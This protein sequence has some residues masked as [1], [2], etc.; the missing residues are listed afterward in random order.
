MKSFHHFLLPLVLGLAPLAA[1]IPTRAPSA[2]VSIPGRGTKGPTPE[3]VAKLK[4]GPALPYKVDASWPQMPD[5]YNFNESSGI[6]VDKEGNVWVA[7][8]G[9]WPVMEF[10]RGGKL[11]QAWTTDMLPL[12]GAHGIR[13]GPDGN[14]WVVD[15]DGDLVFKLNRKGH[16]VLILGI[17]QG[18][19]GNN[20]AEDGFNHP[21]NLNFRANGNVYI[22]DGYV[23]S[24]VIEFTPDG[25]YVRHWGKYGTGDGQFNLV[26]DVTVDSQGRVYVADRSNE[27]VQVFDADG[28]FLN[29]WSGF[30]QPWGLYY[31]AKENAIYMCDG[32]Y[33][34]VTKLSL[35]GEVLGVLGSHGH[36][37]GMLDSAHDIA[38]DTSDMSIYTAEIE[39]WRV[40]K[41]VRQ[42]K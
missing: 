6:D 34:R 28:K 32:K 3:S 7:G 36:A 18:L 42:T 26:H 31:V 35:D 40:Q 2:L 16:P 33:D 21:T 23:N 1:Q 9:R 14:I 39:T 29:K 30:G 27:R 22:S 8:R 5:G 15:R 13:V 38:V 20:D 10:S 19:P 41:W 37:A 11:L 17:R 25:R 24:R 4:S 12:V